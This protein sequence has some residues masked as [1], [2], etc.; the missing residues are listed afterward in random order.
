[1]LPRPPGGAKSEGHIDVAR[2][3]QGGVT[4]QNFAC[5]I[6]PPFLPAQATHHTLAMI[7][8]LYQRIDEHSDDLCLATCA[9]DI[10][11]AK[12]KTR[13]RASSVSK[14]QRAC[15]AAWPHCG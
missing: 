4:A 2:L 9:D 3:K 8:L 14:A 6:L 7:D 15:K 13:S 5:Y 1:M 10:L 11:G 12:S